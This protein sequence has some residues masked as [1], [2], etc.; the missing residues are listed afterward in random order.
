VQRVGGPSQF[1]DQCADSGVDKLFG[2]QFARWVQVYP[3]SAFRAEAAASVSRGRKIVQAFAVRL[4]SRF[5]KEIVARA[6][7]AWMARRLLIPRRA[8]DWSLRRADLLA[9]TVG[10]PLAP[11]GTLRKRQPD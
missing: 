11:V 2:G 3:S 5:N 8:C 4:V 7:V 10:N 6:A 1:P 9:V